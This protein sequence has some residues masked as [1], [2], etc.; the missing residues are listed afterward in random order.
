VNLSLIGRDLLHP[1]HVE[2]AGGGA[3]QRYFQREVL[4]RMTWGF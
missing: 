2:L 4:G 1:R 3:Q